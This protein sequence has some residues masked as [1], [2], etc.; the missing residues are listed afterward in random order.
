MLVPLLIIVSLLAHTKA[1]PNPKFILIFLIPISIPTLFLTVISML[2][3]MRITVFIP[4]LTPEL[5]LV[6]SL[7][8]PRLNQCIHHHLHQY[9]SRHISQCLTI[10][11]TVTEIDI[12]YYMFI[13]I[14]TPSGN[15]NYYCFYHNIYPD[16]YVLTQC[17]THCISHHVTQ[18]LS[19]TLSPNLKLIVTPSFILGLCHQNVKPWYR[20]FYIQILMHIMI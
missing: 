3:L 18:G 9:F 4:M 14:L 5:D 10:H 8:L 20:S 19:N 1:Y 11:L 15:P 17:L 13:L 7:L 6:A 12:Y 16:G 2:T